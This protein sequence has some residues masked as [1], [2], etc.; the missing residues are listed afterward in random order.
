MESASETFHPGIFIMMKYP[1][2]GKVK[3]RLAQFIGEEA[4]V[5]LYQVFIQDT[6]AA[7]QALKT[8]FHI[9]V[10]PPESQEKFAK[11]LGISHMY[12]RQRGANL[13]ERLHNGFNTMFGQKYHQVIALA[14]DCPDI[15]VEILRKAV[16]NLQSHKAVIGPAPDGGYYLIG[17]CRDSF[18]PDAFEDI[19]W[20]TETV[21]QET[22][23]RIEGKTK[24][25]HVLPEWRDIDTKSDLQE[26]YTRHRSQKSNELESMRYIRS[27]HKLL[28]V[29]FS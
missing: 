27:H 19:S 4:A 12:F 10:H 25:V 24:A 15:P 26:F 13:G 14:S 28:Q 3:A 5:G 21:F 6:I 2:A 11:W 8:P 18:I 29:L 17:F 22:L 1:E 9:A 16:L 20:S 7:V 23:A